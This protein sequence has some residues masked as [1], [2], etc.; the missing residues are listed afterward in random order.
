MGTFFI[1]LSFQVL[2]IA[3]RRHA[4]VKS[5]QIV[6]SKSCGTQ[7]E[8]CCGDL[9]RR[10]SRSDTGN[11]NASMLAVRFGREGSLIVPV[12]PARPL[13]KK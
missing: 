1:S 7:T 13:G 3:V 10:I 9:E 8:L 12:A 5:P 4:L 11:L 2:D 6:Q